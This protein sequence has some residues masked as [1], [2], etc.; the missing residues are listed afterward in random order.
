MIGTAAVI[1]NT[2]AAPLAEGRLFLAPGLM[3]PERS[4]VSRALGLLSAVVVN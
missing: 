3:L 4:D 2:A 1:A